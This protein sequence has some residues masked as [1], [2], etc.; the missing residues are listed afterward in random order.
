MKFRISYRRRKIKRYRKIHTHEYAILF[1]NSNSL[2][3]FVCNLKNASIISSSLYI[4]YGCYQLLISTSNIQNLSKAK[5]II[6]KDKLHIDDIKL[7]SRL[8]CKDDALPKM[9]KAFRA[10]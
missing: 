3:D 1:D 9:Q 8:I 4:S 2:I 7:K 5:K 10:P 6:F